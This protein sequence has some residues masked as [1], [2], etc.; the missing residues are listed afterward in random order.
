MNHIILTQRTPAE[1]AE[2]I[3]RTCR[4]RRKEHGF[5]QAELGQRAG[6]SLGTLKRFE[7]KHEIS[8]KSLIKLAIALDCEDD[9]DSLF[10][11]KHYRSILEIID[12]QNT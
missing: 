11:K 9:F 4:L 10:A 5:S 7:T 1:I 3:S 2:N 12:E 6:V 8:L